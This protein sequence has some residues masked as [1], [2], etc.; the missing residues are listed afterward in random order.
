MDYLSRQIETLYSPETLSS[1]GLSIF[2]TLDTQVQTA[3]EKALKK[4]LARWEKSHPALQRKDPT[5]KLQ[6]A[7]IVMQPKTGY[8]L[9]MVGGRDYGISQYN[10]IIQSRRQ[11]GSAFKPFVYLAALD[12]F[13]TATR[14]SNQP[15]TYW[16]NG[17][18]WKPQNFTPDSE[19]DVSMR[20]ALKK[21]LNLAT[22]D[23]AMK[24]GLDQLVDQIERFQFSTP[25]KPYPSL[26]LGAFEVIPMELARAYCAFAADGVLPYPLSLRDVTDENDKVLKQTHVNI[27]RLMPPAKSFIL[28]SMLQSVVDDG[29]ARALRENGITWTVAGKTGTSNDYRDAWFVGF[30]PDILGLVWVGFDNGDPIAATGASVA[31]PIWAELIKSLPQY[32][33]EADFKIPPGVVKRTVCS[34]SGL[35]S[36]K[37]DCPEPM[38]E[39]FLAGNAPSA[40]CP[41]HPRP[42]TLKKI[43]KII[44][45]IKNFI[46]RK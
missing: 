34:E 29:T 40:R 1:L 19:P 24:V 28:T 21:S 46:K 42:G 22:V 41:L 2:T 11:P 39:Y 6:G 33:T 36:E 3:A 17:E 18:P 43:E 15:K 23:L 30:T 25:V 10:R 31:L 44:Q 9:A 4:G 35:L 26:A 13:T 14:L 27:E 7:I 12:K 38:D 5:R 32:I 8:V 37:R 20:T 45:G 16:I